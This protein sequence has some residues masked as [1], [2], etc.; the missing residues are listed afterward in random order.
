LSWETDGRDWPHRSASGFVLAA[1]LRWHV[2]QMGSGPEF[3]LIHG[4][5]ASTHSWRDFMPLLARNFH[6]VAVDLP[7]HGFTSAPAVW[8]QSLPGMARSISALL[9]TLRVEPDVIVGHSAGAAIAAQMCLHEGRAPESIVSLN[10]AFTP[11]AG[12][13]GLVFP[14]IAKL[15]AATPL[16]SRLFAMHA[17]DRKVVEQLVRNTGSVLDQRGIDLY[18]QLVRNPRHAHAAFGM[19]AQWNLGPLS[20]ELPRL[21]AAVHLIAGAR[22]RAVPPEH[23]LPAR[24]RPS[25]AS[26]T[27][28]E[29]VGHLAHEERPAAIADLVRQVLARSAGC[30]TAC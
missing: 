23:S 13:P 27:L 8:Q 2:Q 9:A 28:V 4:T 16:V 17:S 3:L 24:L 21:K 18:A 7:G 14:P 15:V 6:C 20:R 12:L 10:G 1:G 19:M 11:L 25:R 5:G 26:Y 30:T 22:D 29:D